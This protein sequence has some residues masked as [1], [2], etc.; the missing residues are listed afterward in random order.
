MN[1]FKKYS[2]KNYKF[3][4]I[5]VIVALNIIGILVIGS[6]EPS[7]QFKQEVGMIV[8]LVVM[9]IVSFIDY[10]F[11]LKFGWLIY[12]FNIGLLSL[13]FFI[14][15]DA[16]GST[17][18]IQLGG[19]R[20]QPSEVS[21]ILVLLFF[22]FFFMK[23]KEIL[24]TFRMIIITIVLVFIPLIMIL[25]QPD[26]STTIVVASIFCFIWYVAGLNGKLVGIVLAIII[27]S[28]VGGLWFVVAKGSSFLQE[29]QYLRIMGWL[30]PEK[31]PNTALQQQN[32]IMAIGSGQLFGKG[33]NNNEVASMKNGNYITAPQ[34]D[35]IYAIVGEE[36]GFAGSLLVLVLLL[37]IVLEC[38]YIARKSKDLAGKIIAVGVGSLIAI[39]SFVNVSVAT[40]LL[41]NT[42]LTLPFVSYGLTS[43]I[44]IYIG[45]G[46][47]LNV[48]L[49]PKKYKRR[50]Y[51]E[52][53]TYRS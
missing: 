1:I 39:Q 29:Y 11:I 20:F 30:Q 51:N 22:A 38:F 6:A 12:L 46:L 15:E 41:P 37:I 13:V 8:G 47:V 3:S 43:L 2:Y 42:G 34:T 27:P 23:Y 52:Y 16:G 28:I 49:Q 5:T 17:R 45:I 19:I 10:T 53:R 32:S 14:G 50:N 31:Y 48:G 35:F 9:T 4:L 36:L 33:L 40:G 18:W 25:K 44:S 26:L 24:N 21:K 7:V